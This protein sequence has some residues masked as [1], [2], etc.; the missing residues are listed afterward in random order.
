M[1]IH[2]HDLMLSFSYIIVLVLTDYLSFSFL[3]FLIAQNVLYECS[4]IFLRNGSDDWLQ[5]SP[6]NFRSAFLTF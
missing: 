5:P 3:L 1:R 2:D 4:L 6:Y